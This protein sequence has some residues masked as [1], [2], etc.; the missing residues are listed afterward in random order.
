MKVELA[1]KHSHMVVAGVA[2]FVD[3]LD[4]SKYA[5]FKPSDGRCAVKLYDDKSE[6]NKSEG[7][8]IISGQKK[9][10]MYVGVIVA[11]GEGVY[12]PYSGGLVPVNFKVGDL[13]FVKENFGHEFVFGEDR[14]NLLLIDYTDL[15]GKAV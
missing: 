14:E 1:K 11:A 12:N 7:G 5:N 10:R 13:V 3:S 4:L 8:I 15:V 6:E 9:D 2:S